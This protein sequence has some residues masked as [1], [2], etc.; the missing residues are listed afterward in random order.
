M[1][2]WG[3][4]GFAAA[5]IIGRQL[6]LSGTGGWTA[7][8][9]A[10]T[11]TGETAIQPAGPPEARAPE[12]PVPDGARAPIE[13]YDPRYAPAPPG[14]PRYGYRRPEEHRYVEPMSP[15]VSPESGVHIESAG[16]W[17]PERPPPSETGGYLAGNLAAL[18]SPPPA[19]GSAIGYPTQQPSRGGSRHAR[20]EPDEAPLAIP[21][22][23]GYA[24]DALGVY[25]IGP[26]ATPVASLYPAPAE[27]DV[28]Q[29][30][31]GVPGHAAAEPAEDAGEGSALGSLDASG[32]FGSLRR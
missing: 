18:G 31:L 2:T 20:P 10:G 9:G 5:V 17:S 30:G 8:R 13:G 16:H 6:G 21:P 23:G 19:A 14:A 22:N 25:P 24:V 32:L 4:R 11:G 26:E 29:V 27:P 3:R 12:A 15:R 28:D 1:D 7:V